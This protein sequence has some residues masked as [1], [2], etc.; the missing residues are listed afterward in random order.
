LIEK[1][2]DDAEARQKTLKYKAFSY[3]K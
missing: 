2:L 1:E 3:T